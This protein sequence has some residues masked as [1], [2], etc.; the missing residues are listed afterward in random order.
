MREIKFI[1]YDEHVDDKGVVFRRTAN[2]I[3]LPLFTDQP[4]YQVW[5]PM[6]WGLRKTRMTVKEFKNRY[7]DLLPTNK[8]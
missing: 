3:D 4:T 7:P 2:G 1:E 5:T 6:D 8:E